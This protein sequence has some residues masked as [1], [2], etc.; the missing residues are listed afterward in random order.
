MI[1]NTS[2]IFIEPEI[3]GEKYWYVLETVILSMD[4]KEKNSKDSLILFFYSLQNL[5][6]CPDCREH[7]QDYIEKNNIEKYIHSKEKM[8]FWIYQLRKEIQI[9]NKKPFPS[10]QEY[11]LKIKKYNVKKQKPNYISL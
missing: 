4:N 6:P 2:P 7:F 5:L 3:W 9:R 11:L 10:F 8:F 1:L